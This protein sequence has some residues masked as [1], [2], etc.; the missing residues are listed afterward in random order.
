MANKTANDLVQA[1]AQNAKYIA[2]D[3]VLAGGEYQKALDEYKSTHNRL[4]DD[5]IHAYGSK[6]VYWA[7]DSVPEEVWML[8]ASIAAKDFIKHFSV[9]EQAKSD[10]LNYAS[11]A[12]SSLKKRLMT[13]RSKQDRYPAFPV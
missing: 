12:E 3:E 8:V 5:S 1:I 2:Y 6:R 10:V 13:G 11:G 4:V 7:Y 9:S